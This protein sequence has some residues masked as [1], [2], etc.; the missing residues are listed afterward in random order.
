M[1]S[2]R[3]KE[4]S[5]HVTCMGDEKFSVGNLQ[6]RDY[7]GEQ[8]VDGRLMMTV[9]LITAT[10]VTAIIIIIIIRRRRINKKGTRC[11]QI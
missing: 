3:L 5:G 11:L 7:L 1:T 9:M 6:G 2:L 10:V 8:D 4:L